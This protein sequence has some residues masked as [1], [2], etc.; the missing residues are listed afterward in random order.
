MRFRR[1]AMLLLMT[2]WML[3]GTDARAEEVRRRFIAADSS[4]GRIA[5]IDEGG[6]TEWEHPI[7][8]LHDLQLLPDNHL[9]FQDSWTHLIEVDLKTGETVWEYDAAAAAAGTEIEVHAFQRLDDGRTMIAESGAARIIE[10]G[11]DGSVIRTV[12]LEVEH[13]HVHHDTRLVRV[14]GEHYLVCH[15][16]DGAVREYA[17]DGAVVWSYEVPL[18]GREPR[19]GHGVEA[20]GN[21]CFAALRLESGNTL[22]TTGN[23]H[24]V[25]EVAP[26]GEIVWQLSQRDLPEIE[27]AWVTTIQVLRNGNLVIGN[28]HAGPENPQIIELSRDKQVVWSFRDFE[29]FGNS[30]TNSWIIE[31]SVE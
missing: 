24:G 3:A 31:P 12:P 28:C 7:G 23:G 29:R 19:P 30:L 17:A 5:L 10:I 21:Q 26:D 25:L 1:L 2:C 11:P 27:L 9:L 14:A 13:P 22:I 18:F 15:E 16:N 6:A 4:A 8:P 20:Y